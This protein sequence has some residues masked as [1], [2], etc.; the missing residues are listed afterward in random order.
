MDPTRHTWRTAAFVVTLAGLAPLTGSVVPAVG[1]AAVSGWLLAAQLA[2]VRSVRSTAADATVDIAVDSERA[3]VG[4]PIAATVTVERPTRAT[5]T[6]LTVT[7]PTPPVAEPIREADRRVELGPSETEG[8]TTFSIRSSVPGRIRLSEPTW[9]LVDAAGLVTESYSQGPTAAVDVVEAADTAHH[10]GDGA[11]MQPWVDADGRQAGRAAGPDRL[12]PYEPTDPAARIDWH[13]TARLGEP[14]VRE[15]TTRSGRPTNLIVDHRPKLLAGD[16]ETMFE[17]IRSV[18]LGVAATA[19]G[20]GDPLGLVTVD[21]EGTKSV[22][23]PTSRPAGYEEIRRRLQ[24][25]GPTPTDHPAGI[26]VDHAE[27]AGYG[28]SADHSVGRLLATFGTGSTATASPVDRRPLV[29]AVRCHQPPTS[30]STVILTDDTDRAELRAAVRAALK[31]GTVVVYLTPRVRFDSDRTVPPARTSDRY[32][33]FER[34]RRRL[35]GVESVTVHEVSPA[36][37]GWPDGLADPGGPIRQPES[38]QSSSSSPSSP[39][40]SS[41]PSSPSSQSTQST[42]GQPNEQT[43][44]SKTATATVS[45]GE[46]NE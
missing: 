13:T 1:A 19:A 28:G 14:Y 41:S 27:P 36:V 37:D 33:Q 26:E 16:E 18:A 12:R 39:S 8:S 11:E 3:G 6:A 9:R 20:R 46:S 29:E 43:G 38:S 4:T 7:Y 21:S 23:E 15:T 31:R 25:L 40:S 10:A 22:V 2:A 35:D 30:G 44:E 32:R 45:D 42:N 24:E 5:G 17:S 34:F